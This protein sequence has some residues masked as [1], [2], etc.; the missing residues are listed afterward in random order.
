MNASGKTAPEVPPAPPSRKAELLAC[1]EHP[2]YFLDRYVCIYDAVQGDWIPFRLWQA[3]VSILETLCA[4]RLTVILKARQ[5]GLTWLC[6]GHG[7]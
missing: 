6:L 3:Q 5:L 1:A 2:G 7:L 4:E